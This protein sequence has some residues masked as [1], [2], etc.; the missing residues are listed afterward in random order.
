MP[1]I[2]VLLS[3]SNTL[4]YAWTPEKYCFHCL[5]TGS[6]K[7]GYVKVQETEHYHIA[8][9]EYSTENYKET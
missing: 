7:F 9:Q 2:A 8:D 3:A 1:L 4:M 5:R 6:K